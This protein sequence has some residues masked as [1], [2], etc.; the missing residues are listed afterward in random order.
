[1]VINIIT[2]NKKDEYKKWILS[3]LFA[4]NFKIYEI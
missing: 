1:M 2:I 3:K 4:V